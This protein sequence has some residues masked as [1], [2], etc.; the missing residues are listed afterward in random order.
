LRR[1]KRSRERK[2]R[3]SLVMKRSLI[4]FLAWG[5]NEKSLNS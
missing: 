1:E 3:L 2:R 4:G 5:E